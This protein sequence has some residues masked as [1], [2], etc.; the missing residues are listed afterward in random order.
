MAPRSPEAKERISR[1]ALKHGLTAKKHLVLNHEDP[2][3]FEAFRAAVLGCLDPNGPLESHIAK[4][5]AACLWRLD[6][7]PCVE[8]AV[9]DYAFEDTL[10]DGVDEFTP[11]QRFQ[12]ALIASI[13]NDHLDPVHRFE[14]TIERRLDRAFAQLYALQV[15]RLYGV[16]V[17]PGS[18][19]IVLPSRP[20]APPNLDP[21]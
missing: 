18:Y 8:A 15:S 7:A 19:H 14:A 3:A 2:L 1:N 20:A 17:T 4:R 5:I 11:A 9:M 12:R 21:S 13:H 10:A 6:R 16:R